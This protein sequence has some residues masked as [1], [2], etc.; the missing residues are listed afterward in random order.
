MADG[1]RK[2][3]ER[4]RENVEGDRAPSLSEA[5]SS[6]AVAR[7]NDESHSMLESIMPGIVPMLCEM[8]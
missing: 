8:L 3:A 6:A 1:G 2:F 7:L 4:C 5:I